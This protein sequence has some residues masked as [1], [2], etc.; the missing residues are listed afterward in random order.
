MHQVDHLVIAIILVEITTE[1]FFP[2]FFGRTAVYDVT[3]EFFGNGAL[4]VVMTLF[5]I[6]LPALLIRACLY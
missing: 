2:H 5:V 3:V 1:L 6:L 4:R